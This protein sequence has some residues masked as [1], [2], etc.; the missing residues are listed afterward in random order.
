MIIRDKIS[1]PWHGEKE[2]LG[3]WV[4]CGLIGNK[5]V[6]LKCTNP[7]CPSGIL[8]GYEEVDGQLMAIVSYDTGVYYLTSEFD[9][10]VRYPL[11]AELYVDDGKLTTVKKSDNSIIVGYV[12]SPPNGV[13]QHLEFYKD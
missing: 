7:E 2:V 6:F 11:N 3:T 4:S 10:S 1:K 9:K 12:T 8:I 13:G 5:I